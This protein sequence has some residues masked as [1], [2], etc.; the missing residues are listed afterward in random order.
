[1]T[2]LN[3]QKR[4][5]V[6]TIKRKCGEKTCAHCFLSNMQKNVKDRPNEETSRGN[7][8]LKKFSQMINCNGV[9]LTNIC[10][11]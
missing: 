3:S 5:A 9:H 8:K 10:Y 7:I 1:M 4:W 6:S 11:C 2:G